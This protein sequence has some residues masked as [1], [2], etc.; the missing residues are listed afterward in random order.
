[1]ENFIITQSPLGPLGV[2]E[3]DG[4]ITRVVFGPEPSLPTTPTPI[5]RQAVLELEEYFA[6]RRQMFDLPLRPKGTPFR[7]K[8]WQALCQIPYGQ[9]CSYAQLASW[10]GNIKACRAVGGANHHNPIPIIIPCHRVIGADGRLT[11]Y[12]GGLGKKQF[13]LALEQRFK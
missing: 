3:E 12:G 4:F 2:A 9:T 10:V 11:G 8:V 1:M 7:I 5:L 13:L 6:G